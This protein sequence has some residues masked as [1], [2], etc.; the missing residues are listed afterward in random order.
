MI[1]ALVLG[2][3]RVGHAI[4]CDLAEDPEWKV[5]CADLTPKNLARLAK[6]ASIATVEADLSDPE[7]ISRLVEPVDIVVGAMPSFLGFAALEQVLTAGRNYVDISFFEEDAFRLSD[8]A[9]QSGATAVVDCGIAPGFDNMILGRMLEEMD[10]V[11]KFTCYV[12]GLPR[13]RSL[14]WEYKAPFAPNDV[15]NEYL[16]P[17]RWV[18]GGKVITSEPLIDV[19]P[20][21]IPGVGTLEAFLTDGL[22]SLLTT[23]SVPEMKE[24]TLRYPGHAAK[25]SL[26]K[27]SGLLSDQPLE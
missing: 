3:G 8:L 12:G 1:R 23:V 2:A 25:I 22:R 14:P 24:K 7:V 15:L 11:E 19:E 4:A 6:R 9:K 17:A 27:S 26:L 18:S 10:R 21:E 5:T 13:E 16:R 20:I